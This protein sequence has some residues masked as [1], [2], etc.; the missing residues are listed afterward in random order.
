MGYE[1]FFGMPMFFGFRN[2]TNER[3]IIDVEYEDLTEED[4]GNS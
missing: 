1:N 3:E 4:Y 2:K